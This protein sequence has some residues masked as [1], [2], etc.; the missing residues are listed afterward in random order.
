M[1]SEGSPYQ[2]GFTLHTNMSFPYRG[3]TKE[4]NDKTRKEAT[5]GAFVRLSDGMTHYELYGT[6]NTPHVVLIHGF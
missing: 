5:S 4:L 2:I 6:R 3:E 1:D